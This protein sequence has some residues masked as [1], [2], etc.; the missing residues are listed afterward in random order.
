MERMGVTSVAT[1][2]TY[3]DDD[4]VP[5]PGLVACEGPSPF[6]RAP[7]AVRVLIHW[8]DDRDRS[9]LARV[10]ALGSCTWDVVSPWVAT[11]W[12]P[13]TAVEAIT[14]GGLPVNVYEPPML[15]GWEGPYPSSW[16]ATVEVPLYYAD[17]VSLDLR[18]IPGV[19]V[20]RVLR[21]LEGHRVYQ[22]VVPS[23]LALG[24][25]MTRGAGVCREC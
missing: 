3:H 2:S 9:V 11:G 25:L 4:P 8:D 20:R 24:D 15:P 19:I 10:T 5:Y 6:P 21:V 16:P 12:I 7:G 13:R 18:P 14:V 22:V 23:V 1:M 17:L